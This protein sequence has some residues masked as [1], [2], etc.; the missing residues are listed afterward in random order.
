MES[1]LMTV[2]ETAKYMRVHPTSIYR[3]LKQGKLPALK[4]GSDWR[5]LKSSIDAWM[6]SAQVNLGRAGK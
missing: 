2:K 4:L 1:P 3:L 5:F 6:V